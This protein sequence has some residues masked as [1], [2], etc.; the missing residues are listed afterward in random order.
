MA[1][2]V[3]IPRVVRSTD[4]RRRYMYRAAS[5]S[6]SGFAKRP[7]V[8]NTER[9]LLVHRRNHPVSCAF[10]ADVVNDLP[11]E[12]RVQ[13]VA[14]LS[15]GYRRKPRHRRRLRED[16]WAPLPRAEPDV[17]AAGGGKCRNPDLVTAT[18]IAKYP[19]GPMIGIPGVPDSLPV[20][21]SAIS[22]WSVCDTSQT[23][24]TKAFSVQGELADHQFDGAVGG[25]R[26]TAH[27]IQGDT[28]GSPW[29]QK[30]T[31]PLPLGRGLSPRPAGSW[32]QP[33]HRVGP[34][35]LRSH[36]RIRCR[37]RGARAD[38]AGILT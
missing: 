8:I 2:S 35:P 14:E 7:M 33:G 32:S 4:P 24:D 5:A 34:A 27:Q 29:H 20:T 25:L 3:T 15:V 9:A 6:Q 36:A 10:P 12:Q 28:G 23:G 11:T 38:F 1:R 31:V 22:A 16:Q 26:R 13:V 30:T 19:T 37:A 18:E 21:S 17:R